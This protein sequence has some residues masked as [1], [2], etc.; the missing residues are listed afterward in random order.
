MILLENIP[1][2]KSSFNLKRPNDSS[3]K[4]MGSEPYLKYEVC[5]KKNTQ[6]IL[7][8]SLFIKYW[9]RGYSVHTKKYRTPLLFFFQLADPVSKFVVKGVRIGSELVKNQ[10]C[11][12]GGV[13]TWQLMVIQFPGP[14]DGCKNSRFPYFLNKFSVHFWLFFGKKLI[15]V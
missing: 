11:S 5:L 9:K 13:T 1:N 6:I 14:G 2:F 4:K 3:S 15:W 10:Y 7:L 12:I 8:S